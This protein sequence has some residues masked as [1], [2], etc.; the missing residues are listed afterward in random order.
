MIN[1]VIDLSHRND[2]KFVTLAKKNAIQGIIHKAT[3][4]NTYVDPEYLSRAKQASEAGLLWGAYHFLSEKSSGI[5]QALYFLSTVFHSSAIPETPILLALD[6]EQSPQGQLLI[7]QKD[8]EDFVQVIHAKTGVWPVVYGDKVD[9]AALTQKTPTILSNCPLWL[10]QYCDTQTP[11]LP[12][13]WQE[14]MLWQYTDGIH[15]LAPHE[16]PNVGV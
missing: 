12:Q 4:D 9:L 11:T 15:G 2:S 1:T 8:S 13:A 10:A 16:V 5:D 3:E 6:L 14:W 7:S